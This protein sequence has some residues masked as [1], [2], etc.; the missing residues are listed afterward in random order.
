MI[1]LGMTRDDVLDG[2]DLDL[3]GALCKAWLKAPPARYLLAA[4]VG[5]K[6][7]EK[8]ADWKTAAAPTGMS[9]AALKQAFPGGIIR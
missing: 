3:L 1:D 7:P 2:I 6:A 4:Y 8:R 5:Y 9:I